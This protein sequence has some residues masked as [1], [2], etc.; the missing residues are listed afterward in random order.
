MLRN[1]DY[2][3]WSQY[4]M[5]KGSKLQY[6][7]TYG[8]LEGGV[9]TKY[10]NKG[11]ELGEAL[12]FGIEGTSSDP[13]LAAVVPMVPKLDFMEHRIECKLLNGEKILSYID[14]GSADLEHFLEYKTGKIAWTQDKVNKHD[15]LL[16]YALAYYIESGRKTVPTC[17]LI[18]IE[19]EDN[20]D[21]SV[22]YTGDVHKF[23]R[24]FNE[25][26]VLKFEQELIKTIQ[27]IEDWDYVELELSDVVVDRYIALK[28]IIDEATE[29]M[30]LIKLDVQVKMDADE[31]DFAAS[32]N[33]RFSYSTRK[34]WVYSDD[35][36]EVEKQAKAIIAKSRKADIKEGKAVH[37]ETKSIRF[38]IIKSK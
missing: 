35:C 10:F 33:G 12:E 7:K 28:K 34:S 20:E 21:G 1:K 38:N 24:D 19:T 29:E 6:W 36:K 31:V 25:K 17:Q 23:S 32:T 4:S 2:L 15:Q 3:S 37:T 13:M 14:S 5:F 18:W 27:E 9:H 30:N 8:L 26:Q 16:F 22:S 11:N